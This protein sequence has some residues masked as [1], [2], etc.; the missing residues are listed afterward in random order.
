MVDWLAIIRS[1]HAKAHANDGYR[2]VTGPPASNAALDALQEWA[3]FQLPDEFRSFYSVMDGFGIA[4]DDRAS[5]D[6]SWF[7]RPTDQIEPFT[8]EIRKWFQ[9]TH[10]AYALRF[11]SFI[12]FG[13]GDGM[14]YVEEE[15]G[16]PFD[17]LFCFNHEAYRFDHD[18]DVNEFLEY[19]PVSLQEFL[20]SI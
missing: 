20:S 17:A 5:A 8:K 4:D 10:E 18:Q 14:G 13:N 12:D 3:G 7:F 19:L 6:T 16:R 11:L 2:L 9:E 15:A 1:Y